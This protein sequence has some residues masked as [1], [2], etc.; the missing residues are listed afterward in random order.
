MAVST[1]ALTALATAAY[2][3]NC[4]L[5]TSVRTGVVDSSGFR[6]LHHALYIGTVGTTAVAATAGVL[7]GS[8]KGAL[9][10]PALLPLAFL[11]FIGREVH[12]AVGLAPAPWF[13]GSLL[14]KEGR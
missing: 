3:A 9:L 11:P 7:R 8:V 4:T 5:G 12:T 14:V 13:L 10:A 1:S 2:V 6:W